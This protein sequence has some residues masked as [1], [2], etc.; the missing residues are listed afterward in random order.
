ME[1][2]YTKEQMPLCYEIGEWDGKRSDEIVAEDDIGRKHIV[3]VYEG[4]MDGSK[5]QDWI[6][7]DDYVINREIVR[8]IALP[9]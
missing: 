1:W 7:I 5:F 8:W 3:R 6:D 2:K 9:Q 4:V